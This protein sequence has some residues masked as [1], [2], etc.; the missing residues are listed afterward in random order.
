M[1]KGG[2]IHTVFPIVIGG[3]K[4]KSGI[5]EKVG[6]IKI[7]ETPMPKIEKANDVIIKV[8]YVG[9]CGSDVHI[10]HGQNA[11][12]K[13]PLVWGHEIVGHVHEVGSQ[14]TSVKM[15][16]RVVV[17]PFIACGKCYSCKNG[18]RNAC[19]ELKVFGAHID[20]GCAEY[21]K[22]PESNAHKLPDNVSLEDAV[23]IEPFTIGAQACYRGQVTKDDFVFVMGGGTIGLT[24]AENAKILGARVILSDI[25]DEKLDFAKKH[26]AEFTINAM[27]EN[28][29]DR[30]FEIT[31]GMGANVVI[32]SICNKKSFEDALTFVSNAGRVVE[33]SFNTTPSEI[34]PISLSKGE[35]SIMGSR[36]Q[37]NRFPVVIDYVK[38]EKIVFENFITAFYPLEEMEKAFKYIEQNPDKTRKIVIKM[39]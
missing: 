10:Y 9:I 17:E 7:E 33:L 25:V 3:L 11:F 32:D 12:A 15:G 20:G 18:R 29:A 37:T 36:H 5:I 27:K 26:G 28:V 14:V 23:L 6:V 4:M 2:T 24:V 38:E 1:E 21:F 19:Q 16:D 35:V 39:Y 34:A 30:I 31:G 8:K 13:Y 22:V